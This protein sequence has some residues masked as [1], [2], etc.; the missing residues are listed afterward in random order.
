MLTLEYINNDN[1]NNFWKYFKKYKD[2]L[3]NKRI[4]DKDVWYID[5][6]RFC[7]DCSKIYWVITFIDR[8]KY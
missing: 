5:D 8:P 4:V 2:I 1:K 3:F 6:I 7:K